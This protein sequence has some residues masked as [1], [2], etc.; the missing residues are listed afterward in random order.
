MANK[1]YA[2]VPINEDFKV[3]PTMVETE[4]TEATE[5]EEFMEEET[6]EEKKHPIKD[7]FG[8]NKKKILVGALGVLAFGSGIVV[9]AASSSKGDNSQ[10]TSNND[11]SSDCPDL[12]EVSDNDSVDG[13]AATV[14]SDATTVD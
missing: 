2:A 4:E 11:N 9:G 8:R 12:I 5:N 6:M 1:T 14:D 13:T 7:W 3:D 10:K